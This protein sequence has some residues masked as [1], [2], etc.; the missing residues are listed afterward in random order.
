MNGVLSPKLVRLV[1][2]ALGVLLV[3]SGLQADAEESCPTAAALQGAWSE[4]GGAGQLRYEPDRVVLREKGLLRAAT[5]LRR[6]PCKLVLRDDGI[7][8]TWT[9]KAEGHGLRLD[10]GKD[11]IVLDR[12]AEIP[13]S[14]D[15]KPFP[16]PPAGPVPDE[17]AKASSGDLAAR[18]ERD[19]KTFWAKQGSERSA[20]I[21]DNDRALREVVSRYGWIDI[22]RFGKAGAAAAILIAKHASDLPLLLVALPIAERDAR[23]NGGGRELV[24]ILVDEV[25]I[26]TGHKQKY[27]TQIA[28]DENGKP[29]VIPV[30]DPAKVDEYRKEL[31]ILSWSEYLKKASKFYY[32][33]APIRVP[34][35]EE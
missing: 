30:E 31:G 25:L 2:G 18:S 3:L 5:I 34:G 12:L 16:L 32:N 7:L 10:R 13:P 24:S 8:T 29:Y 33:G 1:A 27:G 15:V 6:E 23:E 28:D 4:R 17:E 14:L 19:Q 35:P 21:T 9:L 11:T 22:P 20:V 26:A